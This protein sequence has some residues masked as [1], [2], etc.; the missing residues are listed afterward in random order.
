MKGKDGIARAFYVA[1]DGQRLERDPGRPTG[2][3]RPKSFQQHKNAK[4]AK[5]AKPFSSKDARRPPKP[6]TFCNWLR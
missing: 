3:L 4:T 2:E 6:P 5:T 1:A